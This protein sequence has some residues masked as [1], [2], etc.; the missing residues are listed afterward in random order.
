MKTK[1]VIVVPYNEQ[2][3][4]EFE[5]IKAEIFAALGQLTVSIEHVGST[6]VQGLWAKPVID[7]DVV[8]PD[9]RFLPQVIDKLKNIGYH[10]EGNLGIEGREAFRYDYK[11]EFMLHHLY[12]CP[13]NSKELKRHL[14]FRDF[15]RTHPD[16]VAAY[17]QVKREG[18]ALFPE[19][20]DAY[21]QY[22][23]PV[24]EKIYRRCG[25]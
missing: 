14:A 20:I 11:P 10:Y 9:N 2:W 13:Q 16:A 22:K 17:S 6:S 12:V 3:P 19:N 24:I 5:K 15:L 18:A 7:I 1:K 8:I 23:S 4:K 21:I 25:L